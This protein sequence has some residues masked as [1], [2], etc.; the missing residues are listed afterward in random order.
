MEDLVVNATVQEEPL[1]PVYEQLNK[2]VAM[3]NLLWQSHRKL[4][5]T[6]EQRFNLFKDHAPGIGRIFHDLLA[7]AVILGICRVTDPAVCFGHENLTFKRLIPTLVPAPNADQ[8]KWLADQQAKI[9]KAI[10][11][12]KDHRNQRIAH[13]ALPLALDRNAV[14]PVVSRKEIESVLCDINKLM[15]QLSDWYRKTEMVYDVI[16]A[17]D[18]DSLIRVF[19]CA[20]MLHE[21]QDDYY[22]CRLTPE[23]I[24]T[25]LAKRQLSVI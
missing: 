8:A 14:L 13:N 3:V 15:A 22:T 25:K 16:L 11:A 12:L 9:D 4:F 2:H 10:P 21:L 7:D 18:A 17:G 6:N 20:D 23:E 5:A 24:L 1:G 19:Q